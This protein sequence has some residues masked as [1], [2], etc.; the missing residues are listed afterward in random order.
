MRNKELINFI[1]ITNSIFKNFDLLYF[2][3]NLDGFYLYVNPAFSEFTGR[4]YNDIIWHK[5]G[6]V[7]GKPETE[8]MMKA[9]RLI[10]SRE[11]PGTDNNLKLINSSGKENYYRVI[12]FP[13]ISRYGEMIAIA[14][15]AMDVTL[16]VEAGKMLVNKWVGKLSPQQKQ[17]IFCKSQDMKPGE[18][19]DILQ[20]S[21]ATLGSQKDRILEKLNAPD[22]ISDAELEIFYKV[23][24]TLIDSGFL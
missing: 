17:Y 5:T 13:V 14:G 21:T 19:A 2:V 11:V 18:I 16:P 23:Y 1:R 3:K 24:K 10:I 22:R 15:Q 9:D 6:E 8:I 20:T 7:W 12:K 4:D